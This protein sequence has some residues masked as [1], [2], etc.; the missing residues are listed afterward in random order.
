MS[1][2]NVSN[3]QHLFSDL[4]LKS[5][6]R[7][8][9]LQ[10]RSERCTCKT[11]W[12]ELMEFVNHLQVNPVPTVS[13][14]K[15]VCKKSPEIYDLV[16]FQ[17]AI[18]LKHIQTQDQH[19]KNMYDALTPQIEEKIR[20]FKKLKWKVHSSVVRVC[21]LSSNTT[22]VYQTKSRS[23]R[24]CELMN[25]F[26]VIS[27]FIYEIIVYESYRNNFFSKQNL[28]FTVWV[29]KNAVHFIVVLWII[30]NT[31]IQKNFIDNKSCKIKTNLKWNIL[32]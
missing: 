5:N 4:S 23:V 15:S 3:T 27:I 10:L 25:C 1:S 18:M 8:F 24:V 6:V 26:T 21:C 31:R 32:L 2:S 13:Y 11:I 7:N 20:A 17:K 14:D 9:V 28:F 29:I 12:I 22:N 16:R 19:F 30:L